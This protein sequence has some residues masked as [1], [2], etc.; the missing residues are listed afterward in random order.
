M[1]KSFFGWLMAIVGSLIFFILLIY[2]IFQ[3]ESAAEIIVLIVFMLPIAFITYWGIKIILKRQKEIRKLIPTEIDD[4]KII[5]SWEISGKDWETYKDYKCS[6]RVT[7]MYSMAMALFVLVLTFFLL[8]GRLEHEGVENPVIVSAI[9]S[10]LTF[11]VVYYLTNK[12]RYNVYGRLYNLNKGTCKI[13]Y[14][15]VDFCGKLLPL[16]AESKRVTNVRIYQMAKFN[17]M[18]IH[19]YKIG[20]ASFFDIIGIPIPFEKIAEAES[21]IKEIKYKY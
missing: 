14:E 21:L 8:I 17:L 20:A 15:Y 13:S 3:A 18:N 19:T 5:I 10:I 16:N 12:Y 4:S 11:C 7:M 6:P 1:L 2:S 9:I